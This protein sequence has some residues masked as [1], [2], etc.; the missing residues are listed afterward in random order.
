MMEEHSFLG[1]FTGFLTASNM[2]IVY[3]GLLSTL[4]EALGLLCLW[5][6]QCSKCTYR[7]LHTQR[8]LTNY[9]QMCWE[10]TFLFQL[11]AVNNVAQDL[12]RAV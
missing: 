4:L 3:S 9:P 10:C 5:E 1:L 12:S 2:S 8:A 11:R 7:Y 6:K